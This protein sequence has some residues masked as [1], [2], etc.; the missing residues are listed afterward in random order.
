MKESEKTFVFTNNFHKMGRTFLLLDEGGFFFL[1]IWLSYMKP[2]SFLTKWSLSFVRK[3]WS[4]YSKSWLLQSIRPS[5]S[6]IER[7]Y[8]INLALLYWR[9]D[10]M[11]EKRVM[12]KR[13]FW[14]KQNT[15]VGI[16]CNRIQKFVVKG[17]SYK[18][19]IS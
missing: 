6:D 9:M 15:K 5:Q 1:E 11:H 19:K 14:F 10:H 3:T 7:L 18:N 12:T 2:V 13:W 16:I 17:S 8:Q 4:L